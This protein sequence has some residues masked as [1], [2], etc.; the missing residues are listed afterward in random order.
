MGAAVNTVE[1]IVDAFINGA[2]VTLDAEN[3]HVPVPMIMPL[4]VIFD[5]LMSKPPVTPDQLKMLAKSNTTHPDAVQRQFGFEPLSFRAN[6]HYLL[7]Y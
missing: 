3:V 7:D 5:A 2:H 4:A 6:A 1:D